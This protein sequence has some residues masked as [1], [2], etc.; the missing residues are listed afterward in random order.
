MCDEISTKKGLFAGIPIM[1]FDRPYMVWDEYPSRVN[2]DAIRAVS[3]EYFDY[4]VSLH[5]TEL[6]QDSLTPRAAVAI[7]I[8]YAHALET[9]FALLF[10]G[11]QA[12][13]AVYAWLHKYRTNDLT[14]LAN[15]VN[16]GADFH[17]VWSK[18]IRSW[19]DVV[20]IVLKRMPQPRATAGDSSV[21]K[22]KVLAWFAG[23]L[24]QLA[25]EFV[26]QEFRDEYNDAKHGLRLSAGGFQLSM[27]A[28]ANAAG[29]TGN[30][31]CLVDERFGS[32]VY[33]VESIPEARHHLRVVQQSRNWRPSADIKKL[34]IASAWL[35]CL[36]SWLLAE[37]GEDGS[38]IKWD[39]FSE[40]SAYC[41][42]WLD[43]PSI[44]S[45]T[46]KFGSFKV[47]NPIS[48]KEIIGRFEE[49]K[50]SRSG[51]NVN[52]ETKASQGYEGNKRNETKS[53]E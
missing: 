27:R 18:S 35:R 23:A 48:E 17:H 39:W 14:Q 15:A 16:S 45:M 31:E 32:T 22:E 7:R 30:F 2:R 24:K 49:R 52:R 10:A 29:E 50:L 20:A 33:R 44:P 41:E 9:V 37:F 53:K 28:E 1:V 43:K 51:L 26:S 38:N 46:W 36:R 40:E 47:T 19:E 13:E 3:P 25:L 8:A 34:Q 12:P 21:T 4:L 11:L 5:V 42:P 6:V